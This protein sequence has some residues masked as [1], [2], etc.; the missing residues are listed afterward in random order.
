[1][2]R[3]A[4]QALRQQGYILPEDYRRYVR[5]AAHQPL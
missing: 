3:R 5:E 2:V 4:A 1:L